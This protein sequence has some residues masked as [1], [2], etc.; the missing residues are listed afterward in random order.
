MEISIKPV[1]KNNWK[2]I[3]ELKVSDSQTEFVASNLYSFA[4]AAYEES[5]VPLGIFHGN[6]AVGFIMYESLAYKDKIG[7]YSI[8]RFM[9]SEKHQNKGFGRIALQ[10]TISKISTFSDCR[11]ITICYMPNN[12]VAKSFYKSVGFSELGIDESGEIL[13]EIRI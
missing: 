8:F 12:S 9:I 10:K 4:E 6:E 5:S 3:A 11:R 13:A 7:E 1:D 2:D